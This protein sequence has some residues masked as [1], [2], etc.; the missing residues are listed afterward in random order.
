MQTIRGGYCEWHGYVL[1]AM[2]CVHLVIT[3]EMGV[4]S[5]HLA[6]ACQMF[7]NTANLNQTYLKVAPSTESMS[8]PWIR[9]DALTV[10]RTQMV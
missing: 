9:R 7:I 1:D 10:P 8:L 5:S 4:L 6:I 3:R 2:S